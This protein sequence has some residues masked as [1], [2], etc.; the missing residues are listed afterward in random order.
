MNSMTIRL[1]VDADIFRRVAMV[2]S[3][4]TI[5]YYLQGVYIEQHPETG[6]ILVATDGHS[7]LCFWDRSGELEGD[8]VIV[9]APKFLLKKMRKGGTLALLGDNLVYEGLQETIQVEDAVIK[10]DYPDWRRVIPD[11]DLS[12]AT[13]GCF[14]SRKLKVMGEAL[15][16]HRDVPL[17]LAGSLD[18]KGPSVALPYSGTTSSPTAFGVLMPVK[19][20]DEHFDTASA[21]LFDLLSKQRAA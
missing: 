2:R 9:Y 4:D 18:G 14:N 19:F 10:G 20:N 21:G 7:M 16:C 1:T 15:N 12:A 13:M 11:V 8:P 17:R 6:V 5:R 3:R